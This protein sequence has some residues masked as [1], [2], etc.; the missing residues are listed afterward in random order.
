MVFLSRMRKIEISHKT[1]IFTFFVIGAILFF[2]EIKDIILI[3]FVSLL[4]TIIL[5]PLVKRISKF[6]MPGVISVLIVYLVFL[7]LM[8]ISLAGIIPALIEQT[9]NFTV[10]LPTYIE[11][12]HIPSSIS[13]QISSQVLS[14]VGDLSGNILGFGLWFV[15]N[16]VTILTIFTFAFY[17]L[18]AR[19]NLDKEL[20]H[21]LDEKKAKQIA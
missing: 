2:W 13:S 7:G 14:R 17:L 19:N 10:G 11:N 6:K 3:L 15:S 9:T 1:I 4:I 20:N 16:I 5:N 21:F 12:L 18:M 8:I